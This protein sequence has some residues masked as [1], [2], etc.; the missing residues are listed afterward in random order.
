MRRLMQGTLSVNS[1]WQNVLTSPPRGSHILQ[2]YDSEDFLSGAVAHFAAAGLH[3][4][5]VVLLTG[6]KDHLVRI[7]RNLRAAGIDTAAAERN[8]QLLLS[9]VHESIVRVVSDGRLEPAE[10]NAVACGALEEALSD[11][12]YTGVRWWGEVTNTLNQAGNREAGLQAE[13]LG[14]AAARKYGATVFCSFL[15]D[16]FDARGYDDALKDLCCVHSHVIPAEDY[17][18]Y[19]LA[20][21]RAIAEVVGDIRGTLLQS[22]TSWK[23]LSCDLPSSQEMLFWLREAMPE[24]FESVLQR[25]KSYEASVGKP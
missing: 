14:D 23:G 13:K 10:F 9:D 6:T 20:V 2:L 21:N 22:L 16:K 15:C 17:V 24:R 11:T 8:G 3:A 12:R 1:S 25:A 7:E 5:A 18:R 4:E 19:R